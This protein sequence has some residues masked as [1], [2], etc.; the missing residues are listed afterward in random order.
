[1]GCRARAPKPELVRV[2]VAGAQC[3]PDLRGRLQ[4][5]GAYVHGDPACIELAERRRAF[6][7]ALRV[8]GPLDATPVRALVAQQQSGQQQR[9]QQQP[10]QQETAQQEH[11]R[12]Q[13]A[14]S[15]NV[16]AAPAAGS[17]V[18]EQVEKR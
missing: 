7:R 3:V 11:D 6:P 15:Q 8:P 4:G 13:A 17:P 5:R 18:R 9:G 14:G 1:M 12:H 10:G 2:V 16:P